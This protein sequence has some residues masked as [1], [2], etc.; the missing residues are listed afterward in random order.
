MIKYKTFFTLFFA[1]LFFLNLSINAQNSQS[2]DLQINNL[3]DAFVCLKNKSSEIEIKSQAFYI[4]SIFS[5]VLSDENSFFVDFS[6]LNKYCSIL[7]SDDKQLRIFT[8]NIYFN[9]S[10]TYFYYGYIQHLDDEQIFSFFK[11]NDASETITNPELVELNE[12]KWFGCIYFDLVTSR[13]KKNTYYTLLGWDGN[14]LFSNKKIVEV[15][16]FKSAKPK[17]GYN[18]DIEGIAKKRLVFEYSE[19]AVMSLKWNEKMKMI[20]WDHLSPIE[21]KYEGM[22]QYYGPDFTYDGIIFKK[23]RWQFVSDVNVNNTD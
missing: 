4:D 18:F 20:V 1:L 21:A 3:A 6:A 17:F 14:N 19:Q 10:G 11:L 2:F 16:S 13:N 12:N 8:W 7:V 15:L 9:N 23:K 5:V 22:F